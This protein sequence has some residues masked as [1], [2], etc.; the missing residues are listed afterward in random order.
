MIVRMTV[1]SAEAIA[2][3]NDYSAFITASPSSYHAA[4]EIARR[5]DAAGF[6]RVH[7]EEV[8]RRDAGGA[9]FVRD[10][11]VIAWWVPVHASPTSSF[12]IIGCHT[13]SPA[14][15]VKPL[16]SSTTP[17]GWGHIDVEVYGGP[18]INS[19]LDREIGFAGRVIDREGHSHL[20]STGAIARVPQLAIHLDREVYS[21]GLKL[22]H[23]I[24]IHPVWHADGAEAESF[25]TVV[26]REAGL[27]SAEDIAGH[28]LVSFACEAP[29]RFGANGEFFAAGR[30]DNLSSVHAG[31]TAFE[32]LATG[33]DT[34]TCDDQ[35]VA[36]FAAFDHEEVG[37]STRSG[38]CGPILET[39]LRRLAA[40]L[41]A[42]E[43]GYHRMLAGSSCI[44]ADAGHWV[45][46]NYA[47]RHDP[48]THPMP[49][50]GPMLKVNADQRYATDAVG[51]ALWTRACERAGVEHQ[52]FVSNNA[53]PCGSTIGPLT[54]TRLGITTVDVGIGM[55]S[56][57]SA[58]EMTHV[59]DHLA[60]SRVLEEY[61]RRG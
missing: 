40:T 16:G 28:D 41:G 20:V 57:H 6:S 56:M 11:A 9:Y 5:L 36:V 18:L 59:A 1:L 33:G 31:L 2:H 30:Q 53:M 35:A 26:A 21:T 4:A 55:L 22:D 25:F 14:L 7:E 38:A 10:G 15:K 42:D 44:S 48:A 46:P 52:V 43:D 49:G 8:W 13:D 27:D 32:R 54:A 37:S 39:T 61:L 34:A 23:Q 45:H 12:R 19:W 3:V 58:R 24:H 17:D 29:G 51:T 60:L 50:R 47:D